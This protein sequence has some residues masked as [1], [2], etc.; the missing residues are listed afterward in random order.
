MEVVKYDIET[1]VIT[2]LDAKYADVVIKDAESY[3]FVMSGLREYRK[4]RLAVDEWYKEKKKGGGE[5]W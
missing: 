3:A 4:Y 5:K 2:A 1:A